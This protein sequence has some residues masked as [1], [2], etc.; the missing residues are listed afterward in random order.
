MDPILRRGRCKQTP[1]LVFIVVSG[2][3]LLSIAVSSHV[4]VLVC[5]WSVLTGFIRPITRRADANP[6]QPFVSSSG[7]Y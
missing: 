1:W 4:D 3:E 5:N 2:S 6:T 7:S